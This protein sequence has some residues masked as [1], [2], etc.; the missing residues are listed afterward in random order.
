MNMTEPEISRH[1]LLKA[2]ALWL[3]ETAYNASV[4][5]IVGYTAAMILLAVVGVAL[6]LRVVNVPEFHP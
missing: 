1:G 3:V 4:Y 6:Y 5:T 2:Y